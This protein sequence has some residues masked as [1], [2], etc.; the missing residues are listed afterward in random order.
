MLV[1]NC[2]LKMRHSLQ[3]ILYHFPLKDPLL[4]QEYLTSLLNPNYLF[5]SMLFLLRYLK[6]LFYITLPNILEKKARDFFVDESV[7]LTSHHSFCEFPKKFDMIVRMSSHFSRGFLGTLSNI[8][9]VW[10][11]QFWTL[12]SSLP[13]IFNK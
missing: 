1:E 3:Q 6:S 8:L 5:K 13:M 2:N 12:L 9:N 10:M 11:T 7:C 4:I